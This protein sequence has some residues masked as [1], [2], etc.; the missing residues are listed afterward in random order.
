MK[1]RR[2][3]Y[4]INRSEQGTLICRIVMHWLLFLA[5]SFFVLP[6]WQIM[7]SAE[8]FRP[9]AKGT[10]DML[11]HS[12]PLF[13]ILIA[14]LPVFVWDTVKLSNR[15]AG[16]M[17]RFHKAVRSLAAGETPEPIEIR[18]GDFWADF[19]DDF[20]AALERLN[21]Q[22]NQH[23]DGELEPINAAKS[24]HDNKSVLFTRN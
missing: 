7:I 17:Y 9:F 24:D 6:V 11:V 19:A 1:M 2:N 18:K 10:V 3:K 16:P 20:N 8:P 12:A 4:F 21:S 14:L 23:V 13:L 15:F 22:D 5:I